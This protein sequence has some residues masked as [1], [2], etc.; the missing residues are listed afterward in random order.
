MIISPSAPAGLYPMLYAFFAASGALRLDAFEPQVEAAVRGG[1]KGVAVLG[2]GTEVQKLNGEERLATVD[3]VSNALSRRLPLCVTVAGDSP[4][5]QLA[6]ARQARRMGVDWLMLQPPREPVSEERLIAFFGEVADGLDCPIGIQNAPEFLG[7]GLT[8][9]GLLALAERHPN[10]RVVKA[11]TSAIAVERMV[12]AL[13]GHLVVFNGRCGLE[14]PDN[15]RAGVAGMIPGIETVDLQSAIIAAHARGDTE[16]TE[17]LYETL[18]PVI[19][20]SMQGIAH[21][22]T[23]GK[24]IAAHRLRIDIGGA[25]EPGLAPTAFGCDS[26]RRFGER[27]GPLAA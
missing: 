20:F 14:L 10:V 24:R 11:E 23:Y 27:L 9:A 16:E 7:Y 5:E 25:R 1:A 12:Q 13:A 19:S 2:L 22:I 3:A 4:Q 8:A 15:L 17:R 21:F 18:C 26:A 6:F